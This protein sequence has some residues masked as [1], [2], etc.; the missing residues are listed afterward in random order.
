L[1]YSIVIRLPYGRQLCICFACDGGK[2]QIKYNVARDVP[3]DKHLLLMLQFQEI[4]VFLPRK[5]KK[6]PGFVP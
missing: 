1:P 2:T 3:E 4:I 5:M 6:S